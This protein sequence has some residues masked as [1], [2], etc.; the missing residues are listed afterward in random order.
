MYLNSPTSSVSLGSF[1][2][3]RRKS[4]NDRCVPE[5]EVNPGILNG[6]YRVPFQPIDAPFTNQ[7][8]PVRADHIRDRIR[9]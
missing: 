6:R 5:A 8:L 2:D 9:H 1:S 3:A 4:L 7:P